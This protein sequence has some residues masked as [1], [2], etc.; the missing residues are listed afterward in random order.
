ME[1]AAAEDAAPSCNSLAG[2][3]FAPQQAANAPHNA[4]VNLP[5]RSKSAPSA[6]R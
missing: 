4:T 5:V 6:Y 1:S 3:A 2:E